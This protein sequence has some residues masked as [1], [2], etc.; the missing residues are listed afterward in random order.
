[1]ASWPLLPPGKENGG[2]GDLSGFA[3]AAPS[4]TRVKTRLRFTVINLLTMSFAR[5]G[6]MITP[7]SFFFVYV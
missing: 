7:S 5:W 4:S 3:I 2:P 6:F 1:M